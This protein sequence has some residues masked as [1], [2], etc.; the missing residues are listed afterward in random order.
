VNGEPIVP[1]PAAPGHL[2]PHGDLG[3]SLAV[4]CKLNRPPPWLVPAHVRA[5]RLCQRNALAASDV[6]NADAIGTAKR[7]RRINLT[8][9]LLMNSFKG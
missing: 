7:N 1:G 3:V 2:C 8:R 6:T 4:P 9:H 5:Q